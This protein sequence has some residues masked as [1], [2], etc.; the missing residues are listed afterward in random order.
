VY[1][2]L[3]TAKIVNSVFAF[4]HIPSIAQNTIGEIRIPI[5]L[6]LNCKKVSFSFSRIEMEEKP[7]AGKNLQSSTRLSMTIHHTYIYKAR[8]PTHSASARSSKNRKARG[9]KAK[10]ELNV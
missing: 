2:V 10:A 9:E 7:V 8:Q 6:K 4:F 1:C 5:M 3:T